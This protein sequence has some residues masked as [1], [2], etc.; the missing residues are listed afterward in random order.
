ML[1]HTPGPWRVEGDHLSQKDI[2]SIDEFVVAQTVGGLEDGEEDANARLIAAAP[3]LLAAA[4]N[5]ISWDAVTCH[6]CQGE[7]G[8]HEAMM[9]SGVPCPVGVLQNAVAKARAVA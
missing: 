7:N 5:L 8:E 2:V 6:I 4:E 3:D 9:L 1:E